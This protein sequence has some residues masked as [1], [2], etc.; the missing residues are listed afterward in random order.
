MLLIAA[1]YHPILM[2]SSLTQMTS[3]CVAYITSQPILY[4][5]HSYAFCCKNTDASYDEYNDISQDG[6]NEYHLRQKKKSMFVG[7]KR[8]F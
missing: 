2:M 4:I 6:Y 8:L 7:L 1:F 3:D 5:A